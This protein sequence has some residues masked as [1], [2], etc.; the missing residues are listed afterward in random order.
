MPAANEAAAGSG[1]V[2]RGV[3]SGVCVRAWCGGRQGDGDGIEAAR[4]S[5]ATQTGEGTRLLGGGK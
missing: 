4:C 5:I 3:L 2:V 1:S